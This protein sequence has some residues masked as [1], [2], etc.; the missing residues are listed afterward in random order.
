MFNTGTNRKAVHSELVA[1]VISRD[2]AAP[3]LYLCWTCVTCS[4]QA[5]LAQRNKNGSAQVPKN[6]MSIATISVLFVIN[7][8]HKKIV[9]T[10]KKNPISDLTLKNRASEMIGKKSKNRPIII[11]SPIRSRSTIRIPKNNFLFT[12]TV[13]SFTKRFLFFIILNYLLFQRSPPSLWWC[14]SA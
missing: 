5:V 1:H 9:H 14:P 13:N 2:F 8:A 6:Q 11:G 12:Q 4:V 7:S 3:W 10:Q